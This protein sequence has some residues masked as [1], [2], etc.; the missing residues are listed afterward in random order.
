MNPDRIIAV[1]SPFMGGIG[2]DL[3]ITSDDGETATIALIVAGETIAQ[4]DEF[5]R[6]QIGPWTWFDA[7]AADVI[8]TFGAFLSHA[9]EDGAFRADWTICDDRAADWCDEL[10]ILGD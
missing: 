6:P 1:P 10:A 4:A 8:G 5:R 7:P 3:A 2:A 9:F